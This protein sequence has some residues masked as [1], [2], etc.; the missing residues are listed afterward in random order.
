MLIQ[1]LGLHFGITSGLFASLLT[2]HEEMTRQ[3]MCPRLVVEDRIRAFPYTEA[4]VHSFIK[5]QETESETEFYPQGGKSINTHTPG[6][7]QF[8]ACVSVHYKVH[9]ECM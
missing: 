9:Y 4:N 2:K 6:F 1:T 8:Y 3:K 5:R 7:T